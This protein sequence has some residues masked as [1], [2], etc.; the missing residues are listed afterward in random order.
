MADWECRYENACFIFKKKHAAAATMFRDSVRYDLLFCSWVADLRKVSMKEVPDCTEY[1]KL[2]GE[3]EKEFQRNAE[4]R[5]G[6]Q[7]AAM[8]AE[9]RKRKSRYDFSTEDL[10]LMPLQRQQHRA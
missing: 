2:S 10:R 8:A 4:F 5:A 7:R 1:L 3:W 6:K 9:D